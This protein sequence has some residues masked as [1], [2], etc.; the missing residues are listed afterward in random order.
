M[1]ETANSATIPGLIEY[2]G[3]TIAVHVAIELLTLD[4]LSY[5]IARVEAL[6]AESNV[7][8]Y[9]DAERQK[10]V[11]RADALDNWIDAGC[12][13]PVEF[14]VDMFLHLR[15]SIIP[16]VVMKQNLDAY[17]DRVLEAS[18]VIPLEE[19]DAP[20]F[21]IRSNAGEAELWLTDARQ[22][23]NA[24]LYPGPDTR[25]VDTDVEGLKAI[26]AIYE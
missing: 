25:V 6:R 20:Q 12:V 11:T 19:M 10:F 5:A 3:R 7:S 15:T 8:D 9:T 23:R 17:I 4:T 14:K 13:G 1:P 16:T 2:R 22:L 21:A 18:T 24:R 26:I